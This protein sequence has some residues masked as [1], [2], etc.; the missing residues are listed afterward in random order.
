[1]PDKDFV[2]ALTVL[3]E[4]QGEP[5]LTTG[6]ADLDSLLGG[7]I[8]PG[9]FYLFYG[10][11]ESGI[12]TL[13]HHIL[14]NTLLPASENGFEGKAVYLNCGNYREEKTVLDVRQLTA[15]VKAAGLNPATAMD[16]IRVFLAFN[17]E[18]EEQV[19]EDVRRAILE[20]TSVKTLV[21]HNVAKLFNPEARGSRGLDRLSGF[22][23]LQNVVS[24]LWQACGSRNVAMVASCRPRPCGG[25]RLPKPEGG[26]Y[27][28][29]TSNILVYLRKAESNTPHVQ[30]FLMKHPDR[31]PRK[32]VFAFTNGGLGGMGRITVPFR[33]MLQEEMDELKRSYREALMNPARR[34][35]F[36]ALMKACTA[37]IGAMSYAKVPAVLD[38][39]LLTAAIDNRTVIEDLNTRVTLLQASLDKLNRKLM[40]LTVPV[41]AAEKDNTAVGE[42]EGDG[43]DS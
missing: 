12:D 38:V 41:S 19:V 42:R 16:G 24:K 29:H 33:T 37:E 34:E 13:L 1:M 15:F 40:E 23:H 25:G 17:E 32:I 43:M 18:H 39:M 21:V 31:A 26:Q 7:G 8:R 35:A 4:E 22:T 6:S 30:A 2:S 20:D 5:R 3:E 27:L 14:V 9:V 11:D 36:D 10:D 28:R